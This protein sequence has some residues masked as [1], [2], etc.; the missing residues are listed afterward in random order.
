MEINKKNFSKKDLIIIS[1][2]V[3]GLLLCIFGLMDKI[4][5][6][7]IFD[8]FKNLTRPYLEK[9]Y[10]ESQKLFLT[11]SLLKGAADVIEG[12]TVNVNMILGMQIEVGDIIQPVYDLI[13]I[14][15]KV[16]LASVVILK[17]QNIYHEIFR[18]KLATILIFTSLISFLPYTFF[19]NSFT[20]ILKK[21]SK[22]SFFIL[23][24]IYIVIPGTIFVNSLISNYFETEYKTPAIA[25]L[26]QNLEKL[27]NVK[28][29]MLSLDQSKS[30]FNIPGQIDSAKQKIDN[31]SKEINNISQSIMEN[32]PIIIG[33]ILL[34]T[35]IF[36]VLLMILLYKLTKSI[37]FEKMLKS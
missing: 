18:V 24:Y 34:T 5:E 29:G 26:N 22:Y 11:L 27:N 13:N 19:K 16:S 17:I 4:F 2:I 6:H 33:I 23:I 30:I 20:E 35:I 9:T 12:S 10:K 21:I 32:T 14:I 25:Q 37:I 7:T 15:W 3:L 1:L 36:P 31:F 28:D 8:F